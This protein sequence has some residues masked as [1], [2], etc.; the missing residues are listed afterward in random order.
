MTYILISQSWMKLYFSKFQAKIWL[1]P[2]YFSARNAPKFSIFWGSMPPDHLCLLPRFAQ[3]IAHFAWSLWATR[4]DFG[5]LKKYFVGPNSGLKL[6]SVQNC[7]GTIIVKHFSC[8]ISLVLKIFARCE[9]HVS[10]FSSVQKSIFIQYRWTVS[11]W[12]VTNVSSFSI[13]WWMSKLI[14]IFLRQKCPLKYIWSIE[15]PLF[16]LFKT[17]CPISSVYGPILAYYK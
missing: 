1:K 3:W 12:K 11:C 17:S 6:L 2:F 9:K 13:F 5:P 15:T 4:D 7:K 8:V 10:Y 14:S 16:I